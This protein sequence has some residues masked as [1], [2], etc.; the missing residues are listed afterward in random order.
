MPFA[1]NSTLY[2]LYLAAAVSTCDGE[3]LPLLT[4]TLAEL[5][6]HGL[7]PTAWTFNPLA[8]LA[9]KRNSWTLAE[10]RGASSRR[11]ARLA[12]GAALA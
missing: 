1:P 3:G 7:E 5:A 6:Q 11:A 2:N 9:F 12:P 10:V 4:S 8:W